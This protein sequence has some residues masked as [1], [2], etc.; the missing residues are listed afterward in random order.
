[1]INKE[2][3]KKLKNDPAFGE[4]MKYAVEQIELIDTLDALDDKET[5]EH[6]GE[7]VRARIEARRV[8]YAILR[9]FLEFTERKE[10]TEAELKEAGARYG[11]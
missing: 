6:L 3:I 11:L 10:P 4:F 2:L 8:L 9:P 1:M 7:E 5:N